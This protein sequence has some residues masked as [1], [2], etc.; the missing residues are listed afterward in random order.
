MGAFWVLPSVTSSTG[1]SVSFFDLMLCNYWGAFLKIFSNVA[2]YFAWSFEVHMYLSLNCCLA[3][4]WEAYFDN[5][6]LQRILF[7]VVVEVPVL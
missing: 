3:I 4:I 2:F 7:C 5:L 1:H 6:Y